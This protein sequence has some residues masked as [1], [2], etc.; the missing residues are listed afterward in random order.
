MGV[1]VGVCS[2]AMFVASAT[3][4]SAG[5]CLPPL[6][7]RA[8]H[9]QQSHIRNG[10][11]VHE[12]AG[13]HTLTMANVSKSTQA[14]TPGSGVAGAAG[15]S[16]ISACITEHTRSAICARVGR[17][18]GWLGGLMGRWV[19]CVGGWVGGWVA[20]VVWKHHHTLVALAYLGKQQLRTWV[21]ASPSQLHSSAQCP[22][23]ALQVRTAGV[24]AERAVR[25]R[26][27]GAGAEQAAGAWLVNSSNSPSASFTRS[28]P[29][30][31]RPLAPPHMHA[32]TRPSP[33]LPQALTGV[34][35]PAAAA[36]STPRASP[37]AAARAGRGV[38]G[39]RTNN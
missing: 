29:L 5:A 39:G 10:Q 20:R 15:A 36:A 22:G 31:D 6:A 19:G 7:P 3:Q 21:Y 11:R 2:G 27:A 16:G 4:R 12:H 32:C 33:R 34:A 17:T 30:S 25:G 28:L 8:P 18:V 14:G 38:G 23:T 26:W 9:Q 1:W 35:A 24:G 13:R 37:E